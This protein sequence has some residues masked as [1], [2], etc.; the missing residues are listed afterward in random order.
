M[1]RKKKAMKRLPVGYNAPPG[2]ARERAIRR[3]AKLYK[4][5]NKQAAFRLREQMEKRERA[6]KK[7]KKTRKKR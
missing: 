6:K 5:G 2:S 7:S 3:A 1:K 4:S